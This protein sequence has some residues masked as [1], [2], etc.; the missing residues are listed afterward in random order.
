MNKNKE[1]AIEN[2]QDLLIKP[3]EIQLSF[4][5]DFLEL[6]VL[7]AQALFKQEVEEKAGEK[8]KRGKSGEENKY[9][10]WGSNPGS[11]Q[12][13]EEKIPIR[14]PRLLNKEDN[15][16]KEVDIYKK[17]KQV[18]EPSEKL[19]KK[20]ILGLSQKDYKQVTKRMVNSFG[21][22]QST[23]SRRFKEES[24]EILKE[25]ENRDLGKYDFIALILD[26]KYL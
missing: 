9:D 23:I 15:C 11:I 17:M 6:T 5:K 2:L 25:F 10:R 16:K 26:G 1:K 14:V 22:S 18:E 21:L 7:Y 20:I 8:Y 3:K 24:K 12:A 4:L 13:G 19:L